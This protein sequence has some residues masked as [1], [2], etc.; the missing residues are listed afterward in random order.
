MVGG[1][2]VHQYAL[3]GLLRQFLH[4]DASKP[5]GKD[6]VPSR[7][8]VQPLRRGPSD[9][10]QRPPHPHM[11]TKHGGQVPLNVLQSRPGAYGQMDLVQKEYDRIRGRLDLL[12]DGLNSGLHLPSELRPH[13]KERDLTSQDPEI[14]QVLVLAFGKPLCHTSDHELLAAAASADQQGIYVACGQTPNDLFDLLL[15]EKVLPAPLDRLPVI[16]HLR[17]ME[18]LL[19]IPRRHL[20]TAL[21]FFR[22][23]REYGP[24]PPEWRLP[25]P[26]RSNGSTLPEAGTESLPGDTP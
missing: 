7:H 23:S 5:T 15:P 13:Q 4:P 3:R 6:R 16:H 8:H 10:P 22:V 26:F 1:H 11:S 19:H 14:S 24:E 21:R 25:C 9:Q 12:H 18:R 2:V 17:E 20:D